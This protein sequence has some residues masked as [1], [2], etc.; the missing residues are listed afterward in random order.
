MWQR[1]SNG[2]GSVASLPILP[3]A[4]IAFAA[5]TAALLAGPAL[6]TAPQIAEGGRRWNT[7]AAGRQPL[8]ERGGV[9]ELAGLAE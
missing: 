4:S 3:T 7:A 9:G 1:T 5:L 8:P 6:A 2:S